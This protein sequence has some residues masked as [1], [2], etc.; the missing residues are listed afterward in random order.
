MH[1]LSLLGVLRLET[2]AGVRRSLDRALLV[3]VVAPQAMCCGSAL[4]GR[5]I[6]SMVKVFCAPAARF[7]SLRKGAS[8]TR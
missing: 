4:H 8:M 5:V 3:G 7:T 1:A 2:C 6:T